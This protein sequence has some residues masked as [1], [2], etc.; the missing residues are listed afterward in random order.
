MTTQNRRILIAVV[1]FAMLA[2]L[3]SWISGPSH[4][5]IDGEEFGEVGGLTGFVI[6]MACA[7][8]GIFIAISVTGLVFVV[9]GLVAVVVLGAVL[10]SLAI[11]MLPFA[12]PFLILYGLFALFRTKRAA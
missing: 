1:I 12:I 4:F 6:A 2:M 8:F 10:G 5:M 9:L 7:F 3:A 11:A